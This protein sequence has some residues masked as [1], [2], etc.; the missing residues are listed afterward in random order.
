MEPGDRLWFVDYVSPFSVK[1]TL[2]LKSV[3]R[4]KFSDRFA[5]GLRVTPG[6]KTVVCLLTLGSVPEGWRATADEQILPIFQRNDAIFRTIS[7]I[8][9]EVEV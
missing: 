3:L 2:A 8:H 9:F 6:G 4:E 1:H 7:Q 5:R